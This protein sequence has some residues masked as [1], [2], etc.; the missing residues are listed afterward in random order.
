MKK[1]S[2]SCLSMALLACSALASTNT[3]TSADVDIEQVEIRDIIYGGA[4][5]PNGTVRAL[6]SED[7]TKASVLFD[8]YYAN[9]AES[10]SRLKR[11]SCNLGLS[12]SVADGLRAS[13][14]TM[15]YRGFVYVPEDG[16]AALRAEYFFAGGRVGRTLNQSWDQQNTPDDGQFLV[17]DR[18]LGSTYSACGDDVIARA[19]TSLLALRGARDTFIHVKDALIQIRWKNCPMTPQ[20][21]EIF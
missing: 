7:K 12:L 17:T 13:L 2:L 21:P 5:C 16:S 9:T 4:G 3:D 20:A 8:T 10:E 19:N 11:V 6:L 18:I 15:D 14:M 1:F